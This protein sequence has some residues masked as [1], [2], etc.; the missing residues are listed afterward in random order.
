MM[1]LSEDHLG[2]GFSVLGFSPAGRESSLAADRAASLSQQADSCAK[3]SRGRIGAKA[4][5]GSY[6]LGQQKRTGMAVEPQRP[7]EAARQ[8]CRAA[9]LWC[10]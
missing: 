6:S 7:P 4:L 2:H 5:H 8:C 1:Y 9:R 10:L 3:R